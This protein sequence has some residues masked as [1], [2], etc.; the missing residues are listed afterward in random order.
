MAIV[1]Y[2]C[3]NNESEVNALGIRKGTKLTDRPKEYMLRV[4]MDKETL[5]RLDECC[6]ELGL[7]RSEVARK[8]IEELF[9]QVKK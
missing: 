6:R 1:Q 3:S 9:K 8:G 7:S 4:R 2:N 5:R